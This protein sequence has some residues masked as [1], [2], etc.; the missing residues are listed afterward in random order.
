MSAMSRERKEF[1]HG[2]FTTALEGGIGYWS[3]ASAYR[4]SK[5]GDGN[6]DDLEKFVAIVAEWDDEKNDYLHGEKDLTINRAVIQKGLRLIG[7]RV[8]KVRDDIY[9]N[10]VAADRSNGEAGDIDSEIADCIVQAG[11]FGDIIY[12]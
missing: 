9:K 1:L 5:A 7:D 10:V 2:I 12:G 8:V 11:L 6:V 4:W 3:Q